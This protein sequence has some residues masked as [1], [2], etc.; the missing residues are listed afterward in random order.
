MDFPRVFLTSNLTPL[1][2]ACELYLNHLLLASGSAPSMEWAKYV[3][4]HNALTE[5]R[6]EYYTL[7]YRGNRMETEHRNSR[8]VE[9]NEN[10]VGYR[11]MVQMGWSAGQSLGQ[12]QVK[13]GEDRV[14][15]NVPFKMTRQ[16]LGFA[17]TDPGYL[18]MTIMEYAAFPSIS[19]KTMKV[20][21]KIGKCRL[22][23]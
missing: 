14:Y 3:A 16:G 7:K 19:D 21:E 23:R 2:S 11:M 20:H 8:G 1:S 18:M 15:L 4:F 9:L 5:L 6:R 10:N 12:K 17:S 13:L 22:K